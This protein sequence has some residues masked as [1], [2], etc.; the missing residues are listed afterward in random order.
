MINRLSPIFE[1]TNSQINEEIDNHI[2]LTL[3]YKSFQ[4]VKDI[5]EIF[6]NTLEID[7]YDIYGYD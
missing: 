4:L 7:E 6:K 3:F 5:F 2:C 1:E